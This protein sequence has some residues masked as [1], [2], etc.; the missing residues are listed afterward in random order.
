MQSTRT[1]RLGLL[2]HSANSGNLGVGALTVSNVAILRE[3]VRELGGK[4]EFVIL[5]PREPGPVYVNDDDTVRF[6]IDTR[7]VLDPRQYWR[8]VGTLDAV[9][10][11]GGGDSFAEVYGAKRFAFLWLTKMIAVWRGRPLLLS[12]QTIGPF[13]RQPWRWLAGHVMERAQAVVARDPLS[14]AAIVEIAPNVRRCQ[15]IDVAFALPFERVLKSI[16]GKTVIGINVSGLLFNKG[17]GGDNAFG[18][19]VDYPKLMRDLIARLAADNRYHVQLLTH[20]VS[21]ELPADDDGQV[22]DLLAKEFPSVERVPD[23]A[24]PSAAKSWI[25]GLDFLISGRMHACIAAYSSGVPVVPVAY[26]RKFSGLFEGVLGYPHAV[27][28]KGLSTS[29]ALQ[30]LM[31]KIASKEELK[32]EIQSSL[33]SVEARLD[34]YRDELRHFLAALQE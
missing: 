28:V 21:K 34:A 4:A 9:L 26:S 12:P 30:Y 27:P 16:E 11:I 31:D 14:Y 1:L 32:A 7:F 10:D 25:S 24:S 20:V 22:A 19:D 18:L 5:G 33:G 15:A 8:I 3:I 2:W 13:T 29:A 6:G 17:Y 23:F